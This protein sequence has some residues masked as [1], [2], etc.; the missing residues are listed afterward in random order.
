MP[1]AGSADWA[2]Q[3]LVGLLGCSLDMHML[4]RAERERGERGS[5]GGGDSAVLWYSWLSARASMVQ[6]RALLGARA[7]A[8]LPRLLL[9]PLP[10]LP[11][12]GVWAAGMR[13][14]SA[15]RGSA[16]AANPAAAAC[17]KAACCA[18]AAAREPVPPDAA[19]IAA[20]MAGVM[21][22]EWGRSREVAAAAAA[23]TAAEL[24]CC[25]PTEA[26]A[27]KRSCRG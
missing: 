19:A 23:A 8:D 6:R 2:G 20:A 15:A 24:P 18:A 22:Q 25:L 3:E 16:D 27:P 7:V 11:L 10:L 9:P 4:P 1:W 21:G 14:C 26:E 17:R 5:G 12:A 13:A